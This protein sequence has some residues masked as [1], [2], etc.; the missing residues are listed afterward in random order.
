M[1]PV[2][3]AAADPLLI[4]RAG[5][6]VRLRFNRPDKLNAFD[7]AQWER[8]RAV[9]TELDGEP[10]IRCILL[11]G[12]DDRA[13]SAGADIA[14]LQETA[15]DPGL[16]RR[17]G[18]LTRA[19][20]GS[21]AA[22]RHPVVAVIAGLC[23]G[24]GLVVAINC[25]LRICGEGA[26]FGVPVK[27]LGL[28]MPLAEAGALVG[29]VGPANALEILLEGRLFGASEALRMG[30]VNRVVPDSVLR[31]EATATAERI[32]EGAPL[33]ARWH[34]RFVRRLLD[35]TPLTR[36][37]LDESLACFATEDFRAG[38]EAFLAK[39]RS[40]FHGR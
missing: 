30:L 17:Y 38:I 4:E 39:T 20:I 26:R 5:P 40:V 6:I 3:T 32:A 11:T 8:L 16:Q 22:C 35:P 24:G 9:F 34:K 33:V 36:A 37:E 14:E 21:I 27:R 19:A 13:F 31:D 29:L 7:A 28:A 18:D 10:E 15:A 23:V 12:A 25:D 1:T 2:S